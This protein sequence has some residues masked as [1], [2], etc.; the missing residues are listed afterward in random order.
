MRGI[1]RVIGKGCK[2]IT[3]S[4]KHCENCEYF[5]HTGT[6]HT[7]KNAGKKTGFCPFV[8]CVKRNGFG[9]SRKKYVRR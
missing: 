8:R 6:S 3:L 4:D 2:S 7:V 9:G 1:L 5:E